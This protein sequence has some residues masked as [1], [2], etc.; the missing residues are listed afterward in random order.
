MDSTYQNQVLKMIMNGLMINIPK[1]EDIP[2]E[3]K[4][5]DA[6]DFD[7]NIPQSL[8]KMSISIE[9][10]KDLTSAVKDLNTT[11]QGIKEQLINPNTGVS[12]LQYL[13]KL[14]NLEKYLPYLDNLSRL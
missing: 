8:K 4:Y 10:I 7:N 9:S 5:T 13:D 12:N 11:M 6:F 2:T 3:N 14:D 1:G